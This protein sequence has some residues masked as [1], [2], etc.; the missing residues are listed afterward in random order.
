[1]ALSL[2][3]GSL[4]HRIEIQSLESVQDEVTGDITP[5]WATFC[6]CWANVRP[7][8]GREFMGADREQSQIT[9][10]IK[11][12]Y[13]E[14][15]KPSMRVIHGTHTYN[16]EEVLEDPESAREWLTLPV[17]EIREPT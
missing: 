7:V 9:A 16:I 1:M 6:N 2:P 8:S 4:N 12:R 15:V 3:A 14:G 13:R 10:T 5:L 17:T 11:I